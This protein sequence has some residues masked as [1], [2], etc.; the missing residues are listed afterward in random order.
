MKRTVVSQTLA[1]TLALVAVSGCGLAFDVGSPESGP[2]LEHGMQA[3]AI[4][5]SWAPGPEV[6]AVADPQN[7]AYTGSP[8]IADGGRCD[9]DNAFDCSCHHPACS[10]P[11]PG[12]VAFR[13]FLLRRFEQIDSAGGFQCCRQNTGNTDYLSVHSI[14]R[15]I[16]LMIPM[17]GGDAD[18]TAGDE[19]ANWLIM[20]AQ[21]IGVQQVIWDRASWRAARAAGEKMRPYEGPIPH[22][23]HI[24]MELSVDAANGNTP[25]FQSGEVDG[26]GEQCAPACEGA[27]LVGADCRRGDCAAFGQTCLADPTPRCG[28]PECPREGGALVCADATHLI[29]CENGLMTN[30]GDCGAFGSFCSVA[31]RAPTDAHCV[32][33]L[34]VGTPDTVP[35]EHTGCSIRGGQRLH[36]A[37]DGTFAEEAC[38]AGEICS[39]LGGSGACASAAAECPPNFGEGLQLATV[40]IGGERVACV[41]GNLIGN[42]RCEA[43]GTCRIVDGAAACV[44]ETC[45]DATGPRSGAL[46]C[47]DNGGVARCSA[48]GLLEPLERCDDDETCREGVC[49]VLEHG[50]GDLGAAPEPR[51]DAASSPE[52]PTDAR[53]PDN[54]AEAALADDAGRDSDSAATDTDAAAGTWQETNTQRG[55]ACSVG[56]GAPGPRPPGLLALTGLGLLSARRRRQLMK[57]RAHAP[58]PR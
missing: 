36:C 54:R 53:A 18:N 31:G 24:H 52:A 38:P 3:V 35:T 6:N 55:G 1:L 58:R 27:M 45:F 22:T 21:H 16:D 28:V 7:V 32:L 50:L 11:L 56:V 42:Q 17:V 5:G 48:T 20:N 2:A 41:N 43:G 37:A 10:G 46:I 13:D 26:T 29:T 47:L 40:C 8:R 34:C 4:P 12:T 15:A 33:S 51:P 49:V 14:G 19:V 44:A 39:D 23:D 57:A 25:F 30:F 9:S